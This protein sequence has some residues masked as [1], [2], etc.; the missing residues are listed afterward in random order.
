MNIVIAQGGVVIRVITE[1]SKCFAGLIEPVQAI[2]GPQ[3]EGPRRIFKD[4]GYRI[5]T[6]AGGVSRDFVGVLVRNNPTD[7]ELVS[8]YAPDD[9]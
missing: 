6:K 9:K 3:P 5:I 1:M 4:D 2:I 8:F 7:I